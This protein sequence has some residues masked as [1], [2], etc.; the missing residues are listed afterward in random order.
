MSENNFV[1]TDEKVLDFLKFYIKPEYPCESMPE[2]LLK[3]FKEA[4]KQLP[5]DYEIILCRAADGHSVHTYQK[6]KCLGSDKT[7]KECTIYSVK[8]LSD[9]SIWTI[10][11]KTD[12]GIISSF[13]P[14]DN[15]YLAVQ[16]DNCISW[17][18]DLSVLEKVKQQPILFV[19]IDNV[20]IYENTPYYIV[21]FPSLHLSKSIGMA[22][23][24]KHNGQLYFSTE[25]AAKEYIYL[26]KSTLSLKEV[27]N[28]LCMDWK[29]TYERLKELVKRKIDG[30]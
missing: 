26:N 13:K 25:D 11:D 8:R 27:K 5:K 18:Y 6:N 3:E 14:T 22:G 10:G 28:A 15:G 12:K 23:A 16:F 20:P 4:S 21:E 30:V 1:W 7:V 29:W 19:T 9:N 17:N 24:V 2:S